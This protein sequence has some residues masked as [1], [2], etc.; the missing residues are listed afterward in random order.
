VTGPM[1]EW[2]GLPMAGLAAV[3]IA[4][5]PLVMRLAHHRPALYEATRSRP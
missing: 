4:G 1:V 2:F 3:I 5:I